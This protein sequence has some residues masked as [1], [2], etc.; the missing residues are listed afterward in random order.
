MNFTALPR[1]KTAGYSL[2]PAVFNKETGLP[3]LPAFTG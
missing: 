1:K 3:F 2:E